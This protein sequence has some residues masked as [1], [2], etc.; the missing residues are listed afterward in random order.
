M[1]NN[2]KQ[3]PWLER[4]AQYYENDIEKFRAHRGIVTCN[5]ATMGEKPRENIIFLLFQNVRQSIR[6]LFV[7]CG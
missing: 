4:K 5:A 2:S 3:F 1:L 6:G 7:C